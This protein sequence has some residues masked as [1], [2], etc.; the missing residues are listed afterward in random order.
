[1]DETGWDVRI[2]EP[3]RELFRLDERGWSFVRYLSTFQIG[4]CLV[5]HTTE[6]RGGVL[7]H[8]KARDAFNATAVVG[9]NHGL[10]L[11]ARSDYFG[12]VVVGMSVGHLFDLDTIDYEHKA[13][14]SSVWTHGFGIGVLD[15]AAQRMHLTPVSIVDGT[16][17]ILGQVVRAA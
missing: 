6:K 4:D 1:M 13:A 2:E 5:T 15:H 8:R 17:S 14:A 10:R 7:A 3:W 16:C 12:R 11:E 9:H